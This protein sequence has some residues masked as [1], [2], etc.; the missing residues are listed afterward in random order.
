L[1]GK[2]IYKVP[3]GKLLKILLELEDDLI[4]EIRI[5]GDFFMH[6][7]EGVEKIESSLCGNAVSPAL[8]PVIDKVVKKEGIEMFGLDSNSLAEAIRMAKEDAK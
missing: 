8:V 1:K 3:D 4:K 5:M 6:P 7:E 2:A